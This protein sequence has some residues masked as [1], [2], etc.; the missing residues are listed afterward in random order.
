[1][2]KAHVIGTRVSKSLSPIIF[3][4]WFKKY[5][6]S[7]EYSFKEINEDVFDN[8]IKKILED[9]DVCGF[10]V[11]IP[12]KEKIIKHIKSLNKIWV[13]NREDIAKHWYANFYE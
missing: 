1:M 9:R 10:N 11:T 3:G 12:F 6:I 7:A 5:N 13:C 2:K 4:Y 8:E